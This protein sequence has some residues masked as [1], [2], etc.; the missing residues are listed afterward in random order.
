MLRSTKKY[1]KDNLYG[2]KL[3]SYLCL[4]NKP[5]DYVYIQGMDHLFTN[6]QLKDTHSVLKICLETL[7]DTTYNS[8]YELPA[9]IEYVYSEKVWNWNQNIPALK[10]YDL[11]EILT[12][13]GYNKDTLKEI[14]G[15]VW[16]LMLQFVTREEVISKFKRDKDF[17]GL[18][19]EIKSQY[20]EFAGE[21]FDKARKDI[22][23]MA[24]ISRLDVNETT[25]METLL[26]EISYSYTSYIS[27]KI[28]AFIQFRREM[29]NDISSLKVYEKLPAIPPRNETGNRIIKDKYRN[30]MRFIDDLNNLRQNYKEIPDSLTAVMQIVND[31]KTDYVERKESLKIK[32][33]KGFDDLIKKAIKHRNTSIVNK[34]INLREDINKRKE[35]GLDA[36]TNLQL[37]KCGIF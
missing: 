7:M 12:A 4:F 19:P 32:K 23:P 17:L 29:R 10:M 18:D 20:L 24:K 2:D 3:V 25:D 28:Y 1:I 22:E 16:P 26:H 8:I 11:V 35:K 33:F 34:R 5:K 37:R 31:F 13:K 14:S 9:N 30:I 27:D 21:I 6:R 36:K 15:S